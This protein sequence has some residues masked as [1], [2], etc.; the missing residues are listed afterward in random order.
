MKTISKTLL[1]F[2]VS[3]TMIACSP[4]VIYTT[5][6]QQK[7]KLTESDLK[8]IQFYTSDDIVLYTKE[9]ASK[10]ETDKG[11]LVVKSN[12][13]EERIL[14]KKGTPCIVE[15]IIGTDK[16]SISF[17]VG[18][19]K[20]L[21]F[22][23]AEANGPYKLLAENWANGRGKLTYDNKIYYAS[24][25]SGNAYLLFKLTKTQK[26]LSKQKVAEGRKVGE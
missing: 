15:K 17:E 19:G 12:S 10:T 20:F 24:S 4:K 25:Y 13:E 8:K 14:I 6:V 9:T 16:L 21:V 2:S 26:N 23:T 1:F 18:E 5:N 11:E 22:G 7:Y 3:F